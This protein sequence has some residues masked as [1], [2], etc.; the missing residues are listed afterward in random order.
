MSDITSPPGLAATAVAIA[1]AALAFLTGH[2]TRKDKR[3]ESAGTVATTEASEL[4]E[5]DRVFRNTLLERIT[6]LEGLLERAERRARE[7][8]E[9]NRQLQKQVGKLEMQ[10]LQLVSDVSGLKSLMAGARPA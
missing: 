2:F 7:A 9:E 3:R 6:H 8:E 4:W 1:A 5:Q 10:V